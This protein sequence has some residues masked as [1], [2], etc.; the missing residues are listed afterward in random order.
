M[1]AV[2]MMTPEPKYF[3]MKKADLGTRIDFDL[4]AMMGNSAPVVRVSWM[5]M[6]VCVMG[7]ETHR[8]DAQA[9]A[10]VI[11]VA[12]AALGDGFEVRHD[13]GGGGGD[14]VVDVEKVL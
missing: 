8:G 1:N 12:A 14:R 7:E 9:H 3:A 6:F 2:A 4:A 5:F 11:F 13:G 10:A